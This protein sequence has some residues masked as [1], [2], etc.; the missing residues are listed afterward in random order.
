MI[1]SEVTSCMRMPL[2]IMVLCLI[3]QTACTSD[4]PRQGIVLDEDTH[5]P[6]DSV[7]IRLYPPNIAKQYPSIL[8]I[9]T[10]KDGTFSIAT[11]LPEDLLFSFDKTSYTGLTTEIE[12]GSD[13]I[14]LSKS[15][16]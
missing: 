4:V 10:S 2:V 13:T 8:P 11:P 12:A 16:P 9:Y 7:L 14:Y 5:T 1:P 3:F 15:T 6:I